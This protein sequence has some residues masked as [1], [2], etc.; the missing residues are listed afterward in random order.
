[1]VKYHRI[2]LCADQALEKAMFRCV[3]KPLKPQID[4]ALQTLHKQDGSFQ[5]MT[6]SLQ[7]AKRVSP[8]KLFGVQVGVPDT[9][10]IEKIKHKLTLMQRAYSPIDKVLLLLQICKL[11]YKAMKNKSGNEVLQ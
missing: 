7:R 2:F 9:Q 3:L 1:M 11:I 4:A 8:E 6:D 10:G 5:R